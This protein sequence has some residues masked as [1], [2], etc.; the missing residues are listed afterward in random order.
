MEECDYLKLIFLVYFLCDLIYSIVVSF[1][2]I[3]KYFLRNKVRVYLCKKILIF[4]L[5]FVFSVLI[6]IFSMI[7][8]MILDILSIFFLM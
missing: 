8:V 5:M 1:V 2:F 6:C 4:G 7:I 3:C